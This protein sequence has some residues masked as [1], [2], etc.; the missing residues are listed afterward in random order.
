MLRPLLLATLMASPWA[1]QA[2]Q[3]DR[4]RPLIIQGGDGSRV[5][6]EQRQDRVEMQGGVTVTQGS[7]LLRMTN[8]LW[9]R[10]ADGGSKVVAASSPGAPVRFSQA[11]DRPG[12]AVEGVADQVQYDE[13]S[14]MVRLLGQAQLRFTAG[15]QMQREFSGNEIAYDSLKEVVTA[16]GKGTAGRSSDGARDGNVRVII[17]P[18][19]AAS[20]PQ[21][22]VAPA[23]LRMAPALTPKPPNP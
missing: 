21:P 4:Q 18:K 17:M 19:P 16:D 12:E 1:A 7:L 23:P 5:V 3:A 13:V 22:A 11:T 20:A 15:G 6:G 2:A 9:T 10:Q 8:L 14:G